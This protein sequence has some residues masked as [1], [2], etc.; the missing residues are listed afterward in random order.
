MYNVK[1]SNKMDRTGLQGLCRENRDIDTSSPLHCQDWLWVE[2]MDLSWWGNLAMPQVYSGC[3]LSWELRWALV[4]RVLDFKNRPVMTVVLFRQFRLMFDKGIGMHRCEP[5]ASISR[6]SK[7]GHQ[8]SLAH[9]SMVGGH[10]LD[11]SPAE[12]HITHVVRRVQFM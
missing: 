11:H 8:V 4:S 5:W 10:A 1:S 12:T 2:A 6:T 9:S 3:Q 7:A